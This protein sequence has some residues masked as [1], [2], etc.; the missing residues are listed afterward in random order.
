M[1][2]APVELLDLLPTISDLTGL[3]PV[4]SVSTQF[5]SWE[6]VSL[7]PILLNPTTATVKQAAVSQFFRNNIWG[8]SMRTVRNRFTTWLQKD[9]FSQSKPPLKS[10]VLELYDYIN[11]KY[12]LVN[13]AKSP[14]SSAQALYSQFTTGYSVWTTAGSTSTKFA[15]LIGKQPHDI[16]S[17]ASMKDICLNVE[18][19]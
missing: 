9:I 6:G 19:P 7:A 3:A 2:T 12:E 11:D 1:T 16:S 18:Y 8:Y 15:T 10:G 5:A 17:L 14:D 4:T 13:L